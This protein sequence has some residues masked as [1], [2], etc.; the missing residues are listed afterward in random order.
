MKRYIIR[1]EEGEQFNAASKARRDAE[2]I[3]IRRCYE[4]IVFPGERS[5]EGSIG[6]MIRLGWNAWQNWHS[7][8]CRAEK[9]SL[10]LVQYPHYP[11]KTAI[12]CRLA[13]KKAR[14]NSV[15]FAALVHDLDSL[16]GMHGKAAR[17]SDA[18]VLP[19]FDAVICHNESMKQY[20]LEQGIPEKKLVVLGLFDYLTE[21]Q[22]AEA[23]EG[24]AVAGNLSAEKS[25]YIYQLMHQTNSVLHLYG[26]GLEK[27]E[28]PENVIYHG[29]YPPEELPGKL[30][31]CFGLVWDGPVMK[32]C[33][34]QQGEYLLYNNP[35]KLSLYLAAGLPV[36]AWGKAAVAR[37]VKQEGIGICVESLED[38]D[39]AVK[40]AADYEGMRRRAAA[41]GRQVREG[42][43]LTKALAETEQRL[44]EERKT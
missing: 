20:L 15:R 3:A 10:V 4:P 40:N 24:V 9:N 27:Q 22:E 18:R 12:F 13:M 37:F 19:A 17:Y 26:K 23:G 35:H 29:A 39:T 2:T 30:E 42:C 1:T 36:I 34:G 44:G 5:A 14:K 7:L 38:L 8:A 6:A 28:L 41:L 31:G 16:R 43:F 21:A 11:M 33:I 25:G 32:D